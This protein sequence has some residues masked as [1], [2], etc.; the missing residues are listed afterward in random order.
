[1]RRLAPRGLDAAL[2]AAVPFLRPA[3]TLARVQEVWPSV[4]GPVVGDEAEPV[5][6]RAGTVTIRCRSSVWAQELE[7]LSG[8][9]LERLN[10]ALE[11][12]GEAPRVTTLRF[13]AGGNR[14]G[15]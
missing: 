14:G 11:A 7:L 4:A 2:A 9:L 6:E 8:D 15:A 10:A 5:S 1:V 12:A 13:V 3:T